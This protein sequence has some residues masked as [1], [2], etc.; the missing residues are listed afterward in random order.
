V[1]GSKMG[2]LTFCMGRINTILGILALNEGVEYVNQ[3][4]TYAE[5]IKD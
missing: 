1:Q 3:H 2:N 4:V 5:V